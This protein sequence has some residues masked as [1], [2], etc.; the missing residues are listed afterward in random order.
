M[1][2]STFHIYRNVNMFR[3]MY[4][5]RVDSWLTDS[6]LYRHLSV[7]ERREDEKN[8]MGEML[9]NNLLQE[10]ESGDSKEYDFLRADSR[11]QDVLSRWKMSR[12]Q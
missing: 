4:G 3:A 9:M 5:I 8:V 11:F 6:V 7:K 10:M 12:Q 2:I 1:T